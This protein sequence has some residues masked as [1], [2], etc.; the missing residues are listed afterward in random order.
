M[1]IANSVLLKTKRSKLRLDGSL[2]DDDDFSET[3][4][5]YLGRARDRER[6]PLIPPEFGDQNEDIR[7]QNSTASTFEIIQRVEM[8]R[9]NHT[10]KYSLVFVKYFLQI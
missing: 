7:R 2:V 3:N 1:S 10:K 9:I 5:R 8:V 6:D 4:P